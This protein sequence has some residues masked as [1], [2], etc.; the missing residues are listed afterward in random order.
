MDDDGP[1]AARGKIAR[2]DALSIRFDRP[3]RIPRIDGRIIWQ[4]DVIYASIASIVRHQAA[5]PG[6]GKCPGKTNR[7][8]RPTCR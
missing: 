6:T 2:V 1:L 3:L 4:A 7:V 5:L 8:A